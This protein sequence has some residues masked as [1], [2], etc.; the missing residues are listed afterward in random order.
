MVKSSVQQTVARQRA[1]TYINWSEL[2]I[3]KG[4][5]GRAA[6]PP[7]PPKHEDVILH[8]PLTAGSACETKYQV[9]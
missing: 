2:K 4:F 1:H 8:W 9:P 6:L 3:D 5:Q 7:V